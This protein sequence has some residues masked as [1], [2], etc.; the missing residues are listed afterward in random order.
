[1]QIPEVCQFND[2]KVQSSAWINFNSFSSDFTSSILPQIWNKKVITRVCYAIVTYYGI[3]GFINNQIRRISW[4]FK[5]RSGFKFKV[6]NFI[7]WIVIV[8]EKIFFDLFWLFW[9]WNKYW[10]LLK[11]QI[12]LKYFLHQFSIALK[13]NYLSSLENS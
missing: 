7:L 3:I 2:V 8:F 9:N 6:L 1:M 5:M 11:F 4:T 12:Y 10:K 13:K